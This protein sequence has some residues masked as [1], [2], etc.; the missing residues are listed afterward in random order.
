MSLESWQTNPNPAKVAKSPKKVVKK[1]PAPKKSPAKKVAKPKVKRT[2][3][4]KKWSVLT[5]KHVHPGQRLF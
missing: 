2:A 4:K 5:G 3:A 1:A